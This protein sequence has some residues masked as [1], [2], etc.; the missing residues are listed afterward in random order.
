MEFQ[1]FGPDVF[2]FLEELAAHNE[3]SWFQDNKQRYEQVVLA[4]SL[5]LIRAFQ[6]HLERI[7]PCFVA[8]DRRLGGSLMRIYRDTRFSPDKTPYKTNIG[9]QFRHRFGRD[10]HAPG[11]YLHIAP[12]ECFLAVG[13]WRPDSPTLA[14]IRQAIVDRPGSWRR[15]RDH[16]KFRAAY[17]LE[18]DVLRRAPRGFPADHPLIEDLKRTDFVGVSALSRKAVLSKQLL[19]RVAVTFAA[20]RPFMRFLC[21]ALTLPF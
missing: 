12:D 10:V 20:S 9:I 19:D 1:G 14:A 21:Q 13:V 17:T 11:F 3:R 18:G 8:S 6:P 4:P 16:A 15:A 2:R 5:A 7:S